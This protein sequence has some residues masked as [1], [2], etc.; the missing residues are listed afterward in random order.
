VIHFIS[1]V[2]LAPEAPNATRLFFAYLD[3]KARAAEALYILGD[4]FE[5]WPGDDCIDDAA[6]AYQASIVAALRALADAGVKLFV[7][8]GNRDFLLGERFAERSGATLLPDPYVLST[9]GWQFVLTHGDLLCTDDA[10]YL[11]FRAQIR[12]PAWTK[13]FL[14]K[15]LVERRAIAAALRRKSEEAKREK[16][17]GLMDVNAAATDDFIRANAYATLVHGHTHRPAV[18]DHIVDGIAV[19][20]WVTADWSEERGEYLAWDGEHLSRH[21]LP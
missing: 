4:L 9:D 21:S 19:E 6:G 17:M 1:D 11:A 13:D 20:R 16:R 8:H 18:H 7:L 3:G 14:A 2:H 15:P 10:D 5:V 12:E